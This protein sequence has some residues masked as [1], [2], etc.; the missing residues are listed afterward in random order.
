[1]TVE[2]ISERC[3][4]E[5]PAL[6]AGTIPGLYIDRVCVAPGGMRPLPFGDDAGDE[7]ALSAYARDASSPEGY[8][9]WLAGWLA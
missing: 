2:S 6:A 7:A 8:A 3:L 5:D 4:L 9:R 1:V